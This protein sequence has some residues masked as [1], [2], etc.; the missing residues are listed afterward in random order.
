MIGERIRQLRVQRGFSQSDIEK[1]TGF[2]RSYLSR[3]ENGHTTPSLETLERLAAGFATP[4]WQLF[5]YPASADHSPPAESVLSRRQAFEALVE[6]YALG[7]SEARFLFRLRELAVRMADSDRELLLTVARQL[8]AAH[9]PTGEASSLSTTNPQ[10][11]PGR[12]VY[13]LGIGTA[14]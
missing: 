14:P 2:N 3:L 4:L 6:E 11:W 9:N 5:Y 8:A 12:S 13:G 10:V 7:D 1:R